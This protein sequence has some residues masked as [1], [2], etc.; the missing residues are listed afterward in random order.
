[1]INAWH[2][3][4]AVSVLEAGGVL[5]HATE[6]VWGLA[7]DPFDLNAVRKV[8]ALK[9]RSLGKGLILVGADV[10]DFAPELAGLADSERAALRAS[11]PGAT[12]W[13]LTSDRFPAWI[14]GGR[15][16]V[17]ARVSGHPQVR[18]LSAAFGGP[19]VSTSANPGGRAAARNQIKARAYF[20]GLVDY[21][22][23]GEVLH[24]RGSSCIKMPGGEIVRRGGSIGLVD[25]HGG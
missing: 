9:Q 11:W 13:I 2:V 23:P 4:R 14:T 25:R 16:S 12:T 20:H 15:D 10:K 24:S 17:A 5:L 7:C 6:G 8:L 18:A 1:V 3:A 22:L 21:V 19:M